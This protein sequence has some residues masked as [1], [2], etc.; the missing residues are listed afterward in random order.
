MSTEALR[1]RDDAVVG[2]YLQLRSLFHDGLLAELEQLVPERYQVALSRRIGSTLLAQ[3]RAGFVRAG[4]S[5]IWPV[6]FLTPGEIRLAL[7]VQITSEELRGLGTVLNGPYRMR[8]RHWEEWWGWD[9][10]LAEDPQFFDL[11]GEEQQEA[12]VRW[13]LDGF[14]WL[15]K[16]GLLGRNAGG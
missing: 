16:N 14:E 4:D 3:L 7:C 5:E 6:V 12:L 11:T 1:A 10:A 8:Q 2:R 9:K 15:V 13:Y